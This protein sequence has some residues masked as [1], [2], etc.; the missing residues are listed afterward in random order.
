MAIT[1]VDVPMVMNGYVRK[2]NV[3]QT[4]DRD[5]MRVWKTQYESL[6]KCLPSP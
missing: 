4:C 6:T 2:I 5:A 1:T 3:Q